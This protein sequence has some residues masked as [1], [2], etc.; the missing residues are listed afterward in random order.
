MR[1]ACLSAIIVFSAAA[2]TATAV[3]AE[4]PTVPAELVPSSKV[5]LRKFATDE[6]PYVTHQIHN[7]GRLY[8]T[9]INNGITGN[10]FGFEDNRQNKAAP[11]FY[12]PRYSRVP[13]GIFSGLWVGGVLRNDTLVSTAIDETF[14]GW[15]PINLE[16]WPDLYPDG[17]FKVRSTD[18]S[19]PYYDPRARAQLEF[20][21]EYT[22]T[23]VYQSCITTVSPDFLGSGISG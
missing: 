4:P 13:H 9:I 21:T 23:F 3:R 6:W 7:N 18:M 19:S 17:A 14:T 11:S 22:D 20:E 1:F 8:N 12:Y 15:W 2:F 10:I 16:F 5:D